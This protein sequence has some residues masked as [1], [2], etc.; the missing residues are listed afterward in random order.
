MQPDRDIELGV[1]GIPHGLRGEVTLHPYNASTDLPQPGMDIRISLRGAP[2]RTYRVTAVRA[3]SKGL[4]IALDGIDD[5]SAAESL[6]GARVVL[7]RDR[8]PPLDEGEFYYDDLPGLPVRLPDGTVVGKV[9]GAFRGATDILELE[10]GGRE[11]LVP[12]VEGFVVSVGRDAVV[13][14]PSALE[15]PA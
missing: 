15:E 7:S 13:I 9:R 6:K 3:I 11:I 14:E 4:V 1:V 2:E 10:V 12:A 5:R 8:L